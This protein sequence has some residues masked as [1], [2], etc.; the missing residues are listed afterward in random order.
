M[1]LVEPKSMIFTVPVASIMMRDMIARMARLR[2]AEPALELR[3]AGD[4]L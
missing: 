3:A 4:A 2:V 1:I